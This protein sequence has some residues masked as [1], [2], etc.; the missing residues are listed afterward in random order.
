MEST[1]EMLDE[2]RPFLCPFD[3]KMSEGLFYLELFLPTLMYPHE[4]DQGFRYVIVTVPAVVASGLP[5]FASWRS[6]QLN[7]KLLKES[8]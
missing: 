8:W 5:D 3:S 6:L 7:K 1:Q 2:W 4:Y